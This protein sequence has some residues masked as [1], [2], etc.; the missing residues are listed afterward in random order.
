VI[1][2]AYIEFKNISKK[3]KMGEVEIKALNK[4]SFEID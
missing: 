3:Y 4:A 1:K 2:M